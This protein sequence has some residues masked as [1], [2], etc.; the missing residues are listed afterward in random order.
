MNAK[1]AAKKAAAM[2]EEVEKRNE[3]LAFM[4]M[5]QSKDIKDYN[6]VILSLIDGKS[7]CPWCEEYKDCKLEARDKT[8][9]QEWWLR[10]EG[11][12]NAG[13][14]ISDPGTESRT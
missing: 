10:Y 1:Q 2:V 11:G 7:P 9:C 3:E 6:T 8:G 12:E 5:R 14:G 4:N 13:E